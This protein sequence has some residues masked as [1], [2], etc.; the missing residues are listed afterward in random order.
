L[1]KRKVTYDAMFILPVCL[2]FGDDDYPSDESLANQK[3]TVS[4]G[5]KIW[6]EFRGFK[7]P[8]GVSELN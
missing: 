3:A 5:P 7:P 6:G 8:H 4:I 1:L 2:D